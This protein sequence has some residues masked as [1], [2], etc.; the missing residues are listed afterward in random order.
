MCDNCPYISNPTQQNT[1]GD[2]AGDACDYAP[3]D[4]NAWTVPGAGGIITF[5]PD[6]QTFSWTSIPQASSYGEGSLGT[7]SSNNQRPNPNPC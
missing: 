1:D 5:S 4:P 6:K 2:Q 3:A 7:D